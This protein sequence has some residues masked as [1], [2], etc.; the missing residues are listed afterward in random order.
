MRSMDGQ[1]R[2]AVTVLA[3]CVTVG[4]IG[5]AP[6][7]AS[8]PVADTA[9][10]ASAVFRVVADS[11]AIVPGA[12]D[13][14]S[15]NLEASYSAAVRL[16]WENRSVHVSETIGVTNTSG[17]PIDRIELNAVPARLGGM[18][19]GRVT[20]DATLV[21]ASIADQTIIVP[22]GGTLPDGASTTVRLSFAARLRTTTGGSDWMFTKRNGIVDMYRWLPWV[23]RRLPFD[24]PNFG[25]P[26]V[27]PVSHRVRLT[28]TTDR[29][30]VIATN[31]R[32]TSM[33]SDRLR[34]TFEATDVRDVPITA[35]TDYR[36]MSGTVDG[37]AVRVYTRPGG[38]SASALLSRARTALSRL[39]DLVGPYPYPTFRIAESAGGW[40]ME[41][42]GIVW[43]PRG[44]ATSSLPYL[45]THET[46]HQWFYGLVGND[47]A[48][49]P[50]ADEAS[51][52]F[53]ARHVL[54]TRRASR[55]S[56]TA[57]DRT[58]YRYSKACYYEVVYI[59]GGNLLDDVR[60]KM[61]STVFWRAL[62][63]YMVDQRFDLSTTQTLLTALDDATP[64]DLRATF[65]K[66]F[67][68]YY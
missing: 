60:R 20:V 18:H 24:R 30:L 14:A 17:G 40:A 48:A 45:V 62:R 50:F 3:I 47:Q 12:V 19:L 43:I 38:L 51:A 33:S 58:I 36:A 28:V 49:Q 29:P 53:L 68:A 59:Q 8:T 10:S 52:D 5:V 15:P 46:A 31:G 25:D 22:L 63:R 42:P 35:A 66:R 7:A 37:I 21:P 67:P 27:T 4:W 6:A 9:R 64:L 23:S 1:A 39:A 65:E 61:G 41:S 26:F 56:A 13:R 16:S 32:R 57:L 55:C 54:G 44:T 34:Q 11:S 2:R